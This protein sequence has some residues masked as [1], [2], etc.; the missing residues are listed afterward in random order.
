MNNLTDFVEANEVQTTTRL[1]SEIQLVDVEKRIGIKFGPELKYYV[2]NFGYLSYKHAELYGVNS[3]QFL[4]SDL[5]TQTEYLHK[6]FPVTSELIAIENQGEG[7]YY[8]VDS[9]DNVYEY[10]SELQELTDWKIKLN[11]YILSRFKGI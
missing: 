9:D 7:D 3:N 1:I 11:E 6:Y 4:E 10:D 5:I 2:L 8:M